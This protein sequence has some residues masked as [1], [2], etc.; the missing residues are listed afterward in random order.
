MFVSF[1][2]LASALGFFD[3]GNHDTAEILRPD[4]VD[5]FSDGLPSYYEHIM[6]LLLQVKANSHVSD[7]AK[8]ALQAHNMAIDK[9]HKVRLSCD[10]RKVY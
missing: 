1:A 3:V 4:Q 7:F 5:K 6:E 8:L 2:N 10:K 9:A